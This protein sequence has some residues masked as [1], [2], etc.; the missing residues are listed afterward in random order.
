MVER[1]ASDAGIHGLVREADG[2]HTAA[3][4]PFLLRSAFQPIYSQSPQGILKLEAYEALI[5]PSKGREPVPPAQFF[6]LVEAG[7]HGQVERLCRRLHV[8]NAARMEIGS[9]LLFLNFDPAS[10]TDYAETLQEIDHF[11]RIVREVE[12]STSQIVCEIIETE[13]SS[14]QLLRSLTDI[15]REHNLKVAI[16]DYGAEQSDFERLVSL[17]P[18]I[19]KFDGLWV[20]RFM[21]TS[22]GF[23]LLKV[24]VR[25]FRER[26]IQILFEGLEEHWQIAACRDLG[27]RLLQGY[28]LARPKIVPA[29]ADAAAQEIEE[30][31]AE[32]AA[33][34]DACGLAARRRP[35]EPTRQQRAVF[36]KR[37]R[38]VRDR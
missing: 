2:S 34:A 1:M 4:G 32:D 14:R 28:A 22:E 19:V 15:F 35:A 30:A 21:E 20:N 7:D 6:S 23:A 26:G 11:T 10:F 25:Q 5:R 33:D 36:G 38:R 16:D 17:R 12:L 9:A 37:G 29:Q 24:M 8:L 27:V 18:D 3:Y 13:A 31:A